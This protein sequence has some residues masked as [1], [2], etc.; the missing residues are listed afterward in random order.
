M[1]EGEWYLTDKRR[2][3]WYH[4]CDRGTDKSGPHI[5]HNNR[6]CCS[7]SRVEKQFFELVEH[8]ELVAHPEHPGEE[9]PRQGKGLDGAGTPYYQ[10]NDNHAS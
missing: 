8:G 5:E 9:K 1:V 7:K 4:A 3:E 10:I 2:P 6:D